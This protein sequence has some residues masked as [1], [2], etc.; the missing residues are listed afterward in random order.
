MFNQSIVIVIVLLMLLMVMQVRPVMPRVA[1]GKA[2]CY[3]LDAFLVAQSAVS[4]LALKDIVTV[5]LKTN[6]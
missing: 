5:L 4:I 6:S 3:M 1:Y 2:E